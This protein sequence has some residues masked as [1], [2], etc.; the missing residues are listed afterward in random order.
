MPRK[1][2]IKTLPTGAS[3]VAQ[4]Y[5]DVWR[6]YASLGRACAEAGPLDDRS[7]RI[8]KIALAIGSGLEGALHSHV[9]QG[10]AEGLT[11][12]EIRH[13]AVLAIPT[14]GLPSAVRALTWIDDI[15]GAKRTA[16]RKRR[17]HKKS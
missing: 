15:L 2:A 10:A 7:R 1:R 14:I 3:R 8:A 4:S 9:R 13:I 16:G 6:S 17:R 12:E 11:A 5:E